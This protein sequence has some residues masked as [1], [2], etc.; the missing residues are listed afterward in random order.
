MS[1]VCDFPKDL[2][3]LPLVRQ[4]EFHIEFIPKAAL[5]VKSFYGLAPS[6]TEE[7][8]N[9]LQELIDKEFIKPS[10]LP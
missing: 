10:I 5:V 7:L 9:Q 3:R 8:P 2:L 1:H 6:E 4:V